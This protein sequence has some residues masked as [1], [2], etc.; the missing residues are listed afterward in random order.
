MCS[1]SG[2]RRHVDALSIEKKRPLSTV[3]TMTRSELSGQK[4]MAE[5]KLWKPKPPRSYLKVKRGVPPASLRI[6]EERS[7]T[8]LHPEPLP[9]GRPP[10]VVMDSIIRSL[11]VSGV[12]RCDG[13]RGSTAR[14]GTNVNASNGVQV[15]PMETGSDIGCTNPD[16]S[17]HCILGKVGTGTT[18]LEEVD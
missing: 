2:M 14:T 4:L 17:S 13:K 9:V 5:T 7:E 15:T 11:L 1:V 18:R 12:S 6:K 16:G 10:V 3:P 8:G